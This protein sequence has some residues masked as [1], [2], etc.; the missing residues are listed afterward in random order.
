MANTISVMRTYAYIIL[1][2]GWVVWVMPFVLAKRSSQ[3]AQ[4]LDRRARWGICWWQFLIRLSGRD[5]SGRDRFPFGEYCYQSCP[6]CWHVFFPGAPRA[7]WEAS[8]GDAGLNADHELVMTGH[9]R[10]VRHPIYA[11]MLCLFCGTAAMITPLLLF[12]PALLVFIV[13]TEVR[14][15]VEDALLASRFGGQFG[16][17]KSSV[18]AYVP[19][20]R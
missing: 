11:S 15:R 5:T 14:V 18:P 20:L 4:K 9:Y 6:Y 1:G 17:F 16:Q 2:V 10:F 12:L 8:G 7:L 3:P 13:G 19:F